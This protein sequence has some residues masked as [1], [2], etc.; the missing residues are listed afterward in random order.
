MDADR[1]T[2]STDY[3]IYAIV[4]Y[5]ISR[6][7]DITP[8]SERDWKMFCHACKEIGIDETSFVALSRLHG[9]RDKDS[10]AAYRYAKRRYYTAEE[11]AQKILHFASHAGIKI[12]EFLPD[13]K[14]CEIR[15]YLREK[16]DTATSRKV[17]RIK[18]ILRQDPRPQAEEAATKEYLYPGLL[19]QAER[20]LEKTTL[21]NFMLSEFGTDFLPVF[22][23]YRVGGCKWEYWTERH[24]PNFGL[25]TS[26][27]IIDRDSN[28]HDFQLSPFMPDGHG[29]KDPANDKRKL[30][31]FALS[32][33]KQSD[34]R[35]GWAFFGEH[36]L[37][38]RPTAPVAIVEAPKSA[39]IASFYYPEF[40]WL[41]CLS[42]QWLNSAISIEP[43]RGRE[44][45]LF[46]DR[47][48][49][50]EWR[51]K[52][53]E[54]VSAGIDAGLSDFMERY[55][56]E[57]KD[58]IADILLRLKN[59]G[60]QEDNTSRLSPDRAEAIKAFER[61]KANSP[62]WRE[63]EKTLQLEPIKVEPFNPNTND[64]R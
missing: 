29:I 56:G 33:M 47:D 34:R 26:F 15:A 27:P 40:V 2:K 14:Q 22:Q 30:K 62:V 4:D 18:S 23:T 36:L 37:T 28:L 7:I 35:A 54:L 19:A 9:T 42:M 39:L 48:G 46:P 38:D 60:Q 17:E 63:L 50:E 49:V 24:V 43:L 51:V 55:P 53:Q 10:R 1:P 3:D 58:D 13:H 59:G 25:A 16:G 44:V 31:S 6:G 11:A 20:L 8:D 41:S 5:S 32:R 64:P 52:T 57:P 45:W 21:Y 12:Y 61:I